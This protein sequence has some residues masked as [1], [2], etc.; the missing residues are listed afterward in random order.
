MGTFACPLRLTSMDG[1]RT[2]D[3]EALVD[4]G[5]FH[6][7]VPA[8]LLDRIGVRREESILL[9][10]ADGR[11]ARHDVGRAW[12]AVDGRREVTLVVFG[13]DDSVALVGAYTL[14]GLKLAA[15]PV[16]RCLVPVEVHPV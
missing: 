15:D 4:T 2:L 13:R 1:D 10:F 11:T 12:A 8:R 5:A 6:T 16:T 7:M 14:E 3:L 9:K